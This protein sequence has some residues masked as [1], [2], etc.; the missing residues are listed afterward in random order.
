MS[1]ALQIK[2]SINISLYILTVDHHSKK[3]NEEEEETKSKTEKPERKQPENQFQIGQ[4]IFSMKNSRR[5]ALDGWEKIYTFHFS[6]CFMVQLL[7]YQ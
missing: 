1:E 3:S 6:C 2:I 5:L 4:P 7:R